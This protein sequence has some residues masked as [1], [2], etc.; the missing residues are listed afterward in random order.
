M[1]DEKLIKK[2]MQNNEKAVRKFFSLYAPFMMNIA[3]RYV[4]SDFDA[5]DILQEAFIKVLQNLGNYDKAK[6]E[7]KNWIAKI[8]VN[9]SLMF[10]RKKDRDN[11]LFS[12]SDENIKAV[13]DANGL[14]NL[15][16]SDLLALLDSL[17]DGK[18]IIFSMY[19]I[20]GYKHQEIAEK[21]GIS[22]GT[23]KSQYAKAK[24]MLQAQ[25]KEAV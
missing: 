23:S 3:R 5:D 8:V 21:L 15:Q 19:A 4:N 12:E 18:R 1:S 14:S 10:I 9:E 6:G 24:A 25:M 22:E 11:K 17:P 7:F 2:C 13:N 16:Y 20:D